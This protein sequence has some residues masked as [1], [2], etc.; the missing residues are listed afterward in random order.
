MAS[1]PTAAINP[2]LWGPG[3]SLKESTSL[4]ECV[5]SLDMPRVQTDENL[6]KLCQFLFF[7]VKIYLSLNALVTIRNAIKYV[8]LFTRN[9]NHLDP[10]LHTWCC[11][12]FSTFELKFVS[13]F[14]ARSRNNYN[15]FASKRNA[16]YLYIFQINNNHPLL[17]RIHPPV[18]NIYE[19][20]RCRRQ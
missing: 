19:P 16:T 15:A 13:C 20:K 8:E 5:S 6:P 10:R 4:N 17:E 14:V 3:F 9:R 12:M 11:H 7:V 2:T 18:P 1:R